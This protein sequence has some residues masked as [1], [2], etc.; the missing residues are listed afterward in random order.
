MSYFLDGSGLRSPFIQNPFQTKT[1]IVLLSRKASSVACKSP[2]HGHSAFWRLNTPRQGT[3]VF[4]PS[5]S[6]WRVSS[7]TYKF[8]V[9]S[10][11]IHSIFVL[12]SIFRFIYLC[13]G[14]VEILLCAVFI[15][16]SCFAVRISV[17]SFCQLRRSLRDGWCAAPS[18]A[19]ISCAS[20]WL[21]CSVLHYAV[22]GGSYTDH[23]LYSCS[24]PLSR[25]E[26]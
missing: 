3:A 8:P 7:K 4:D 9:P 26:T 17:W 5:T 1:A 19:C 6:E 20:G 21:R 16:E 25:F 2:L 13:R 22:V 12:S 24:C 18:M 10:C 23:D 11:G 15:V 14:A